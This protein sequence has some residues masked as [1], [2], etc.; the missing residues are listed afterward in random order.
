MISRA[1]VVNTGEWIVGSLHFRLRHGYV[2]SLHM[3]GEAR[4]EVNRT[5]CTRGCR[6]K[7]MHGRE[8]K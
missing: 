1:D 6:K 5:R 3:C 4:R 8:D 7:R 2:V